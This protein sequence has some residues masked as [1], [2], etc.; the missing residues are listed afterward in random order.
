MR[1][2][3]NKLAVIHLAIIAIILLWY[4]I[5]YGQIEP[6]HGVKPTPIVKPKPTPGTPEEWSFAIKESPGAQ[7]FVTKAS[8]VT[9][10]D[11]AAYPTEKIVQSP[12]AVSAVKGVKWVKTYRL[13][14]RSDGTVIPLSNGWTA[15]TT[16]DAPVSVVTKPTVEVFK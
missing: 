5:S 16:L 14:L 4:S 7:E 12:S 3:K 2:T 1:R 6:G 15:Q 9:H 11:I 10:G 8:V 13:W